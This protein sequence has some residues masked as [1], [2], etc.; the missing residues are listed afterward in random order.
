MAQLGLIRRFMRSYTVRMMMGVLF[1]NALLMPILFVVTS[2]IVE[3][4]S[5]EQFVNYVRSYTHILATISGQHRDHAE[6]SKNI[7][8]LVM[9]GQTV[10]A[11]Y[12]SGTGKIVPSI[13]GG[14]GGLR[15]REDFFFG[16]HGDHVYFISSPVR[17]DDQ[18]R[19]GILR[20]GFDERPVE[21][22]ISAFQRMG[23]YL[24]AAYMMLMLVLVGFFGHR[25]TRS[26]RQLRSVSRRI[27][28]G[29]TGSTLMV[30]TRITEVTDL[31]QDL[32]FMRQEL[33]KREEEIALRESRYK[34]ILENAAEGIVTVDTSGNIESF[35][36]A[37]ESIFGYH[38]TEVMHT[39][40]SRMLSASGITQLLVSNKPGVY[41]GQNLIGIKKSGT[42]FPMKIS[43]S[44]VTAIGI[45]VFTL[46]IEDVSERQAFE[47]MLS[48]QALHDALTG[49]PNR[50]LLYDRLSQA[51]AAA[52]REPGQQ[53]VLMELDLDHFK[54]INDTLGHPVGDEV[55]RQVSQ[56]LSRILRDS[57][58]LARLG[59]DEF[60][61]L[62][63][64]V[65]DGRAAAAMVAQIVLDSFAEPFFYQD[66]EMYLGAGIGIVIFPEHGTDTITLMSRADVA[67]Y[68]TKH[69]DLGFM[70]YDSNTDTNTKKKLHLSSEL[71]HALERNEFVLY[72]QPQIDI[73]SGLLHG[74]EALIRWRHP[75]NGII[76][77]DDFI[78]H[79]ERTGLINPITEWV[80]RTALDQCQQWRAAGLSFQ[81]AVNVSA[82]SF[83]DPKFIDKVARILSGHSTCA[84]AHMEMEITES[85]LMTN[86][87]HGADVLAQIDKLGMKIAI[88]DFGT[89]YSSLAYLKKLPITC[90]KVDKSF[91]LNMMQ[92]A[93]DA[94]IV[95]STVE[96]AHNL[97]YKIV[98]EGVEN[99]DTLDLL[100][101][102]G[103]DYAQG[104]YIARPLPKIEF[105]HWLETS[106]WGKKTTGRL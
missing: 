52:Q 62:L 106:Q 46:L 105:D 59:G 10:Y 47:S 27:A 72:Y 76:Y 57:D 101:T 16:E 18:K 94:V 102:M 92:D 3:K 29:H 5:E 42:T 43:V 6:I 44:E 23:V 69:K 20:L 56:R 68:E 99:E 37:A 35:N 90:I 61:I 26:I 28:A 87:E 91:V 17:G 2:R 79:T 14:N 49:L 50:S 9:S 40:F 33:V 98:A 86:I 78:S 45:H 58:T 75:K 96:L 73:R 89:G 7:N 39:P 12:Q 32:E 60:A 95:H 41:V 25:L 51:I 22:S 81:V 36:K 54:E 66:N 70:F 38:A 19:I 30:S 80:I 71:R 104:Y 53:G 93:N 48:Y 103:C 31:A 21:E 65:Q 77:P 13:P 97:G 55:L 82:R 8:D 15:F 63:P 4:N 74:V 11:E 64:D 100:K 88:D 85:V 1:I 67:M 83:L 24:G 34:G 84:A